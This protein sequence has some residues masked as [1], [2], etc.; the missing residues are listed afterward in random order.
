MW[1]GD[2]NKACVSRGGKL[3]GGLEQHGTVSH[4][5]KGVGKGGWGRL[6]PPPK[7]LGKKKQRKEEASY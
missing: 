4:Q 1:G 5:G 3:I 6:K 2:G 7:Y